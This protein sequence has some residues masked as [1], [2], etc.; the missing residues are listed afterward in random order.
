[1]KK[2]VLILGTLILSVLAISLVAAQALPAPPVTLD[3]IVNYFQMLVTGFGSNAETM[4]RV[5]LVMLL[6]AV[7]FRPA[8]NLVGKKSGLAFLIAFLVSVIGIRF[9]TSYDMI[10]GLMLPY[11]A[12]AIGV[13]AALPFL[14]FGILIET[15]EADITLRKVGWTIMAGAFILLWWFRWTDIG[16]LAWIYL[17]LGIAAFAVLFFNGQ[18]HMLFA[19]QRIGSSKKRQIYK[20]LMEL[21]RE[22]DKYIALGPPQ[23]E[24][25]RRMINS[26]VARLDRAMRDLYRHL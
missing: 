21:R 23:D 26:E 22:R 10:Q 20:Q 14:L 17:F 24:T 15:S 4:S 25:E 3:T 6:T 8:Y 18:I 2:G 9:F 7:L 1:M 12:L 16:D 5:L 11:G 13:S 19:M